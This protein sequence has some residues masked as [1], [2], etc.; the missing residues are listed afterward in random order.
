MFLVGTVLGGRVAI[1]RQISK[2]KD[3]LGAHPGW[4]SPLRDSGIYREPHCDDLEGQ[5]CLLSRKG[6]YGMPWEWLL[7]QHQ[8]GPAGDTGLQALVEDLV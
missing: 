3:S 5:S 2:Y 7:T 8:G 6:I 4:F 1:R